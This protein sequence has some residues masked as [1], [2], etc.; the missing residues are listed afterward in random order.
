M[1]FG[2]GIDELKKPIPIKIPTP[3][4]RRYGL[5]SCLYGISCVRISPGNCTGNQSPPELLLSSRLFG[6][7]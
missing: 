7:R 4:A 2:A 6:Q 1:I 5:E 3:T